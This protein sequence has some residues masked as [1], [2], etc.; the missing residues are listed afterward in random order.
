[1]ARYEYRLG[2]RTAFFWIMAGILLLFDLLLLAEGRA[3]PLAASWFLAHQVFPVTSLLILFFVAAAG[4][5]LERERVTEVALSRWISSEEL[6]LARF[7]GILAL[8]L[9]LVGIQLLGGGVV[10][11][12]VAG[13][14]EPIPE[15]L[16]GGAYLIQHLSHFFRD[17]DLLARPYRQAFWQGFPGFLFF[18][19]LAYGL[20]LIGRTALVGAMAALYWFAVVAGRNFMPRPLNWTLSQN[21]GPYLYVGLACLILTMVGYERRRRRRGA[22]YARWL[23]WL[24]GGALLLAVLTALK[25]ALLAQDWLLLAT[26]YRPRYARQRVEVGSRVPNYAWLDQKGRR[27]SLG[28]LRG[29]MVL[30]AF[31]EPG[32]KELQATLKRLAGWW[33]DF[34]GRG[35][36]IIGVGLSDD[37]YVARQVARSE[38]LPFPLVVDLRNVRLAERSEEP[39]PE[40]SPEA[41]GPPGGRPDRE[42]S[43]LAVALGV[44]GGEAVL[45]DREGRWCEGKLRLGREAAKETRQIL[46]KYLGGRGE[47]SAGPQGGTDG[48]L[49][50]P[51]AL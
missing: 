25:T 42:V 39:G 23:G 38:E 30:L 22:P 29:Q 18:S 47:S 24:A 2:V 46:E 10:R 49:A 31:W 27:V 7:G 20:A 41:V 44:Q 37:W 48:P 21:G 17:S 9:T 14:N 45:L 19:A 3:T 15:G 13:P 33:K 51:G 8:V 36:A 4:N 11:Y 5:R 1:V 32:D 43:P 28:G 26:D 12:L 40:L 6:V 35:L 16:R 34:H 50:R